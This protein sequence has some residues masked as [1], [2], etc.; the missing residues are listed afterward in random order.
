MGAFA[1]F[2]NLVAFLKH[3]KNPESFRKRFASKGDGFPIFGGTAHCTFQGNKDLMEGRLEK[4]NYFAGP[5]ADPSDYYG[6]N[7]M[8]F[9]QDGPN[10]DRRREFLG[11]LV[12]KAHGQLALLET[13]LAG[14]ANSEI[15]MVKF[16]FQ[17]LIELE[18]NDDVAEEMLAYRKIAAPLGLLPKWLRTSVLGSRHRRALAIKAAMYERI[19][20]TGYPLVENIFDMLWFNAVS[21]GFYPD[22]AIEA[23]GAD[24]DLYAKVA[25]EV[26]LPPTE[27]VHTRG[28][29][30]EM[31]RLYPKIASINYADDQGVQVACI[32]TGNV[33]PAR[34]EC[35]HKI[36]TERDHSDN[37]TF[38]MPTHRPCIAHEFAPDV[39]A[40]LVAHHLRSSGA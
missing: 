22:K 33:D 39:M 3:I 34:Y 30:L 28:L 6:R 11:N 13:M 20:A 1:Q 5:V 35:P 14:H 25:A 17:A 9:L 8:L 21:L 32:P 38:A 19:A 2:S 23:M 29:V 15:A 31:A 40:C 36:D 27:R 37:L 26:D 18:V 24:A 4:V 10:H 12:T 16:L 7:F